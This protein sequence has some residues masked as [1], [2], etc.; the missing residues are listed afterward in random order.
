MITIPSRSSCSDTSRLKASLIESAKISMPT[1]KPTVDNV[2]NDLTGERV[3]L[4]NTERIVRI[5]AS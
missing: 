4:V 2:T 1:P 3:R 5:I